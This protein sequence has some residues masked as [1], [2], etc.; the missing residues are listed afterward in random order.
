MCF[1]SS[2]YLKP[3]IIQNINELLCDNSVIL[4]SLFYAVTEGGFWELPS[5]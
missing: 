2:S 4:I 3:N 5:D 1:P